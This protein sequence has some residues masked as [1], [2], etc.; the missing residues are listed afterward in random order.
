MS[1]FEEEFCSW[2]VLVSLDRRNGSQELLR[3]ATKS[4]ICSPN[5][6]ARSDPEP[7]CLPLYGFIRGELDRHHRFGDLQAATLFGVV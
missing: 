2:F 5:I 7:L 1:T 6:L 3:L 4:S